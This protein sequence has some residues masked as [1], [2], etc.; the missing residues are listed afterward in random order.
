M[1]SK[2]LVPVDFASYTGHI[3]RYATEIATRFGSSLHLIHVIPN[4]D[5]FGPYESFMAAGTIMTVQKGVEVEVRKNL[6]E[7]AGRVTGI[8]VTQAIR[9][10]TAFVEIISYVEDQGID[11]VVMGT[12]GRGR[13]DHILLGSVAEKVVR[14]SPCPVLTIRPPA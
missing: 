13:I 3:L 2:I 1:F 8:G 11:L 5:Y 9:T 10:G 14:R 12:H 6:E 4:M 7:V